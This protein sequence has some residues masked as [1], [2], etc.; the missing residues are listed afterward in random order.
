MKMLI[1]TFEEDITREDT[2]DLVTNSLHHLPNDY[3]DDGSEYN[4]IDDF[5]DT[6][7][8]QSLSPIPPDITDPIRIACIKKE[9]ERSSEDREIVNATMRKVGHYYPDFEDEEIAFLLFDNLLVYNAW[10]SKYKLTNKLLYTWLRKFTEAGVKDI[11]NNLGGYPLDK[12]LE[13]N[14]EKIGE[15]YKYV[16]H[17]FGKDYSYMQQFREH[18]I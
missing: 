16:R 14:S 8:G 6:Y 5:Y 9:M 15:D 3:K 4:D 17:F 2:S 1:Y 11:C 12:Y 10:K 7:L 18:L 13:E